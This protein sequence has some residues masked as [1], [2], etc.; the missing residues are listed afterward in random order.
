[1]RFLNLPLNFIADQIMRPWRSF[2]PWVALVVV[3]LLTAGVMVLLFRWTSNQAAVRTTRNRLLARTLELLLFRHD[4]AV[5]LSACGRILAEDARY[6][7]SLL[8]P[9]I[10]GAAPIVLIFVQASGWFEGRPLA[11]GETAVLEVQL[12]PT[13][14][15][16]SSEV[17]LKLPECVRLD[18]MAV[19]IPSQNTVAWRL[20]AVAPGVESIEVQ[21]AGRVEPKSVA[22]GPDFVRVSP[23]R[24]AAGFWSEFWNPK[25]PPL[26]AGTPIAGIEVHYPPR[27]LSIGL[28]DIPWTVA[29]LVLMMG[30]GLILGRLLGV[31][32]A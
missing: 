25:E 26:P 31:R 7:A 9:M 1:M 8:R 23:H 16:E 4:M 2:S 17:S 12:S 29:A 11:V 32:L 27:V 22:V 20:A 3:S 24:P 10:V 5:S 21:V 13:H 30:F 14:S 18:S 15:V 28:H 19:R 6:L